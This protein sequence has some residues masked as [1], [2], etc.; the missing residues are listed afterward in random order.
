MD[1]TYRVRPQRMVNF[2]T[3]Y[4]IGDEPSDWLWMSEIELDAIMNSS[5]F[6]TYL[7]INDSLKYTSDAITATNGV[8]KVYRI[9]LPRGM[10]GERPRI[11]FRA[12]DTYGEGNIGIDPYSVRV[13][14]SPSG[15]QEGLQYRR[16]WPTGEAP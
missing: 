12:S 2:D 5:S 7:Y 4:Y 16:V 13:R 1:F 9:P 11:V 6:T 10:K 8:R 3:G 15:N 14:I